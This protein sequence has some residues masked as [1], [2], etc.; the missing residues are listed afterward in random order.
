MKSIRSILKEKFLKE[1]FDNSESTHYDTENRRKVKVFDDTIDF[2][3]NTVKGEIT[4]GKSKGLFTILNLDNL[5]ELN[6]QNAMVA[7]D[8]SN[9][10]MG[11]EDDPRAP[12]NE[13]PSAEIKKI[14][15]DDNNQ[16]F[17]LYLTNGSE[18]EVDYVDVLEK[19]W[20][21]N[22]GEFENDYSA[23][24]D[25]PLPDTANI[26]SLKQKGY[27]DNHFVSYLESIAKDNG[28]L[29]EEN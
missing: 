14:I 26:N 2:H 12:W 10:P 28:W 16:R 19:Y 6:P 7:E 13:K 1:F 20:R 3:K 24:I 11:A 4:S 5:V 9:V 18:K 21:D 22:P 15:Y 17:I 27:T 8:S 29:D 25:E 23:F